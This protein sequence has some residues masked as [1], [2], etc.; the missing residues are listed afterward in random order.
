MHVDHA[1]SK[2]CQFSF[3][4]VGKTVKCNICNHP[5]KNGITKKFKSL[6]GERVAI[7]SLPRAVN[8]GLA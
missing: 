3:W 7:F 6:I 1:A 4:H 5:T 8:E 2:I